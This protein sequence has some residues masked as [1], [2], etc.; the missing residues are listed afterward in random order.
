MHIIFTTSYCKNHAYKKNKYL[1]CFSR[2]RRSCSDCVTDEATVP[3]HQPGHCQGPHH[4]TS[5]SVPAHLVRHKPGGVTSAFK[6][7]FR[8][9]RKQELLLLCAVSEYT[10]YCF[11]ILCATEK[12]M[13]TSRLIARSRNQKYLKR[14]KWSR[15]GKKDIKSLLWSN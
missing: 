7:W 5:R 10:K 4:A 9:I 13:L 6:Q 15:V 11:C 8:G 14:K 12:M 2:F 3:V 1:S